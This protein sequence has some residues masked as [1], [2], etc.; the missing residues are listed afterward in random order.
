MF[1][2]ILAGVSSVSLALGV[3]AL[4]SLA[5]PVGA[6]SATSSGA[7]APKDGETCVTFGEADKQT[8]YNGGLTITK[9]AITVTIAT[10]YQAG[11]N[12]Q[13]SSSGDPL[14]T[15][16]INS[17][18]GWQ[19]RTGQTTLNGDFGA[20]IVGAVICTHAAAVVVTPPPPPVDPTPYVLAAWLMP[21]W[22][23]GA[24][25]FHTSTW[26]QTLA[27]HVDLA[28]KNLN[29]LDA[30]LTTC[31]TSY[32][33]DLYNDSTVT[34]TLITGAH[35]DNPGVPPEDFPSPA[36]WGVTYKLVHNADCL[37]QDATAGASVSTPTCRVSGVATFTL[38][39]ADWTDTTGPEDQTAGDHTRTAHA[40]TG[41]L[42]SNGTD[43]MDVSYT[44]PSQLDPKSSDCF[45]PVPVKPSH[46]AIHGCGVYGSITLVNTAFV[47]YA[48][49]F[50]DGTQGLNVVTAT[51]VPPYTFSS[52]TQTWWLIDLGHYKDCYHPEVKVHLD[53]TC[54]YDANTQASIENLAVTFDNSGS[55]VPVTFTIPSAGISEVVAGGDTDQVTITIPTTGSA[56]IKVYADGHL[57]KKIHEIGSFTGCVPLTVTA[58]P[59]TAAT[60]SPDGSLANGSVD[61]DFMPASVS[62][63]ITGGSPSVNITAAAASTPLPPGTYTVTATAQPGFVL[64]GPSS[65]SETIDDPSPCP[66]PPA[67]GLS[68][69]SVSLLSTAAVVDCD[70]PT[71]SSWPT[72]ADPTQPTC[73]GKD[74]SLTVGL[75]FGVSFFDK[76]DYFLDG[77]PI[78]TPTIPLAPGSYTVT[79]SPHTLGDGLTGPASFPITITPS[80]LACADLK[81]LALT[82]S[83]PTGWI[84]LGSGLLAAG[85][86]LIAIRLGRRRGDAENRA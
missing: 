45:H 26:P 75:D 10:Q 4:T 19:D 56:A 64:T 80:S 40:Q 22:D 5:G 85:L 1:K 86:A 39:H 28:T 82:G 74:G 43:T 24:D 27:A 63:Q 79:A 71:L 16:T 13:V 58:D 69:A 78:A 17:N 20:D 9:G 55:T 25:P 37:P 70:P 54:M 62:Y 38:L 23:A 15:I 76:V 81:T 30:Q 14:A 77:T 83:D 61:V 73:A 35:L 8:F 36:G 53:R 52:H 65:W 57:L 6:A 67:C 18:G 7:P 41:H 72:D 33:V 50:G 2:K 21:S 44:I 31:G 66:Q 3:I 68:V 48:I 59:G 32:Q 42:F 60:C 49:T 46:S 47:T 51:A 84:G 12:W 29:A 11:K 34:T